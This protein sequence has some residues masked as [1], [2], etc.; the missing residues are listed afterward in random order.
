MSAPVEEYLI[1]FYPERCIQCH[2][3]ETACKSWREL[4]HGI[5]Y[6]RVLNLWNGS[7]PAVTSATLSVSCLHCAEPACLEACPVEAIEKRVSDGLVLVDPER[8]IGCRACARACPYGV[9]QFDASGVMVKCD[10]CID[11]DLNKTDI[12]CAATCPGKALVLEKTIPADKRTFEK[13]VA[14]MLGNS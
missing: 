6:R 7:Y 14:A 9:P 11:Q 12:P 4:P 5:Q 8:C 2:G 10:V 1:R 13:A 3:C